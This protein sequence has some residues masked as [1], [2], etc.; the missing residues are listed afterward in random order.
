MRI[1]VGGPMSDWK[2]DGLRVID[3]ATVFDHPDGTTYILRATAIAGPCPTTLWSTNQLRASGSEV[4]DIATVHGGKSNIITPCNADLP[5]QYR[6]GLMTLPSRKH[7]NTEVEEC[8]HIDLS[9]NSW[10]TRKEFDIVFNEEDSLVDTTPTA[11]F[12]PANMLNVESKE[13]EPDWDWLR[14]CL[15]NKPME[16]VKA[17]WNAT[18]KYAVNHSLANPMQRHFISR[19]PAL[20]ACRLKEMFAM[21]TF[22]SSVKAIGG[23]TCA[24]V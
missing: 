9:T 17:T 3:G 22:F 1:S 2:N 21:D 18:T 4:N 20:N 10:D 24:Q 8:D 5:L 14:G 13:K 16:V 7:M 11:D 19:F 12:D 15:L 6:R 23:A